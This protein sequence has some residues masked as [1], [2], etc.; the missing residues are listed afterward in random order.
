MTTKEQH[1]VTDYI[2][3]NFKLLDEN[4]KNIASVFTGWKVEDVTV[5]LY[6]CSNL[7]TDLSVITIKNTIM[8]DLFVD[9]VNLVILHSNDIQMGFEFSKRITSHTYEP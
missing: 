5:W 3:H 2:S 7:K 4:E 8:L 9:Q 1:A 6:F